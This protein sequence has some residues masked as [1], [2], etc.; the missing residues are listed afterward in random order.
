MGYNY[1]YT[2]IFFQKVHSVIIKTS[3]YEASS[4]LQIFWV[5][6]LKIR[7]TINAWLNK[8]ENSH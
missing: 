4:C 2:A 8:I 3:K 6:I 7:T 1:A 5:K